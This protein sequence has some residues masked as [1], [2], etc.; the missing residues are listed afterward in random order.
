MFNGLFYSGM[1]V[2]ST[3]QIQFIKI[4]KNILE[5]YQQIMPVDP[6][7]AFM[8]RM[9]KIEGTPPNKTN[10][11][12]QAEEAA[13]PLLLFN[14]IAPASKILAVCLKFNNNSEYEICIDSRKFNFH[15]PGNVLD[16]EFVQYYMTTI[17]T[18]PSILPTPLEYT[19]YIV[20]DGIVQDYSSTP[21]TNVAGISQLVITEQKQV[22]ITRN[23]LI[24][25]DA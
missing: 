21:C 1:Y 8:P 22:L 6:E 23:T 2:F 24:V 9:T 3:I 17:D 20:Y 14:M 16:K 11:Y 10:Y 13:P 7:F 25:L 15:V 12:L 5:A 18:C 4:L 19:M